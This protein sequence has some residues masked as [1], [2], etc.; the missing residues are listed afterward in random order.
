M[1]KSLLIKLA[2]LAMTAGLIFWIGWSVPQ[3]AD[4]GESE[5]STPKTGITQQQVASPTAAPALTP[6]APARQAKDRPAKKGFMSGDRKPLDLN[7]ATAEDLQQLPGIGEAMAKR[8]LDYKKA[9]GSFGTVEDLLE[10]K[11]IG[12]KKME[13]LRPFVMVKQKKPIMSKETKADL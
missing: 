13:R 12:E 1:V 2:M 9:N 7:R 11:G 10:V 8:I 5:N 3:P 6:R 4:Q